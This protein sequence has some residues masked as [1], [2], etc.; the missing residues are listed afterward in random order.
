MS[1]D[2][3][4]CGTIGPHLE[5][6]IDDFPRQALDVPHHVRP[7]AGQ[8][9]IGGVDAE[10]VD[11]MKDLDFLRDGGRADRRRLQAVA[12][13][14]VI[15]HHPRR[16]GGSADAIP[17]KYSTLPS[18]RSSRPRVEEGRGQARPDAVQIAA[19]VLGRLVRH[20]LDHAD[21]AEHAHV[22]DDRQRA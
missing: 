15:Q 1:R 12:Q 8:A 21:A 16:L 5:P 14:F 4:A 2:G 9:D 13:G 19:G 10:R 20:Q 22:A 11:Q 17:M 6:G 7:G 3:R 18:G